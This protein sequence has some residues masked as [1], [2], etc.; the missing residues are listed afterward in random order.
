MMTTQHSGVHSWLLEYIDACKRGDIIVGHELI[1][2]FDLLL[3]DFDDPAVKVDF[4]EAHKRIKFIETQCRHSEA[5]FAGKPFILML[6]EKALIEAIY[7]FQIYDDEIG[8][9]VRKYQDVLMLVG[10]KNGKTPY[11]SATCLAEWFCG[12][13]GTKILCSSN[14]YE[15]A[16][17]MVQA[18]DAM[19]EQSP[20]LAKVT[21][22]NIKGMF[23]GNPQKPK[24]TGKFSYRNK[25][26]IRRISSKTGAKEGRNIAVGAVDEAHELKDNSS[27]MPIRQALSTQP[28]PL[29]IELTTEGFISDG[30]LDGRL[31]EAR[32][33]LAG[34]LDRPR[35]LIW[36]YTQDSE[37]EIWQDERSWAKSNPSL[38]TVK[39]ISFLR[40]MVEEAKTN[41][42]TR[43]FVLAKDFN[44]KQSTA[45]A[46]LTREDILACNGKFKLED[47]RG[48]V[49]LGATDLSE[50]TDLTSARALIM[51]PGSSQK[52]TFSMYFI[53]Q[54]KL[55]EN[56]DNKDYLLWARDGLITICPGNDVDFSMVTDWYIS[57]YKQW[58]IKFYKIGYDGWHAKEWAKGMESFFDMERVP[59]EKAKKVLSD[60]M[61]LM[62]ADMKG[63]LVNYN[64]NPVDAWCLENL[65]FSIDNLGHVWPV[66]KDDKPTNR[67]DGAVTL[68][69]DYALLKEHRTEYLSVI[70]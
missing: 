58:G 67:I 53:P 10:R 25:G 6:W 48:C 55:E 60:P 20:A 50:T 17:L 59:M 54:S 39:R 30:Y 68:I 9:W 29:Y 56:K 24:H 61:K 26:S 34:E 28:E 8:R 23:F 35:W 12:Q 46:F 42:A 32:Q 5:P 62:E 13:L 38:G 44:I 36:L 51:R 41:R 19:R 52:L 14:D 57:L 18:I 7:I 37:A 15:Q 27:I 11:V 47:L 65:G 64:Q 2:E 70:R 33:A 4:T 22:K 31:K 45:S 63:R 66:K 1:L 69:I 49:A 43:A 16:D 21:R 3:K 40:Q